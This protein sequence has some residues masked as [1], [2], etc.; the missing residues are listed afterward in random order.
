MISGLPN[1]SDIV[2]YTQIARLIILTLIIVVLFLLT[3]LIGIVLVHLSTLL[4]VLIQETAERWPEL[5]SDLL[6]AKSLDINWTAVLRFLWAELK[7]TVS[8][9]VS[10]PT[11][12]LFGSSVYIYKAFKTR[13]S[14]TGSIATEGIKDFDEWEYHVNEQLGKQA[15][16]YPEAQRARLQFQ[17]NKFEPISFNYIEP[18]DEGDDDFKNSS[19][20]KST[21]KK[22]K[23]RRG[24]NSFKK[25]SKTYT[26]KGASQNGGFDSSKKSS[27]SLS[28]DEE[29]SRKYKGSDTDPQKALVEYSS[30][31]KTLIYHAY[32]PKTAELKA[33]L[34]RE[35][36]TAQ[37]FLY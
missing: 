14:S 7:E 8:G 15:G 31:T 18:Y 10:S 19:K 6:C 22:Y 2:R 34:T 5:T 28:K 16:L 13:L 4:S 35:Q 11:L 12:I 26:R 27:S 30:E 20:T 32:P 25:S 24:L 23:G 9:R 3:L 36:V 37:P 17:R 1:T 33:Q 21:S 29:I